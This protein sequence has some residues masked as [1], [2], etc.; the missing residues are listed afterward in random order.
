MSVAEEII[1]IAALAGID[2]KK[3]RHWLFVSSDLAIAEGGGPTAID[4]LFTFNV[5]GGR[6]VLLTRIDVDSYPVSGGVDLYGQ[7]Q[8][9]YFNEGI[10]FFVQADD[11]QLSEDTVPSRVIFGDVFF[12]FPANAKV[13]FSVTIPA[14]GDSMKASFRLHGFLLPQSLYNLLARI[15]TIT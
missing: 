9:N 7:R 1:A 15:Q 14:G 2:P 4:P 13:E 6:C 3:M 8:N 10:S 11:T 12:V 5:P